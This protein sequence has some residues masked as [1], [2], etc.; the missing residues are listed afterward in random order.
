MIRGRRRGQWGA[1]ARSCLRWRQ[2]AS[3]VDLN[4]RAS[5]GWT[6]VPSIRRRTPHEPRGDLRSGRLSPALRY[7]GRGVGIG[8]HHEV[9]ARCLG[10]TPELQRGHR[11]AQR[12]EMGWSGSTLGWSRIYA[13]LRRHE[14][15]GRRARGGQRGLA[16]LHRGTCVSSGSMGIPGLGSTGHAPGRAGNSCRVVGTEAPLYRNTCAPIA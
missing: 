7:G 10:L 1:W 2:K 9:R 16:V 8:Q 3:S 12:L 14:A 15:L 4:H 11:I 6:W 13:P 5:S